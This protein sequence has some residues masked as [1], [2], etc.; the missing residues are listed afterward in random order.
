M[1][2][3][4]GKDDESVVR[5]MW[6]TCFGDTE[7]FLNI[8]FLQKYKPENTLVYMYEG[9]FVASL[10][11]LPFSF[12]FCGEEISFYYFAGLCTL[13][14]YRKRGFMAQLIDEAFRV[15]QQREIPLAILV[16]AEDQLFD[17]Y[18]NF[19]FEKVFD[20]AN[21]TIPLKEILDKNSG[22]IVAAYKEFD[23]RYRT[24]DFCVQKSLGD[25]KTIVEEAE[26]E[27][28]PPKYNLDGMARLVDARKLLEIFYR[29]NADKSFLIK[30]FDTRIRE[31]NMVFVTRDGETELDANIKV[32]TRLLFGYHMDEFKPAFRAIFGEHH[33][34]LNLMLE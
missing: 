12:T 13:P 22:D 6:K 16:P 24:R 7:E 30:I 26:T 14:G 3:L 34:V 20:S 27:N 21:E 28:Y 23:A 18:R 17:Y 11:M 5:A 9:E 33:P 29:K 25:F 15:M 8:F 31:N 32:L 4:A 10:Q 1:I 19:G 2:R